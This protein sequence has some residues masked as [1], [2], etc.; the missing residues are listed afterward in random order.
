M[1]SSIIPEQLKN[2][3]I[4]LIKVEARGKN[5]I[6]ANWQKEGGSNFAYNDPII[7]NWL[8]NG[9]NYGVVTN[10]GLV[11]IDADDPRISKIVDAELP[12]TFTVKSGREGAGGFHYYYFCPEL[13][14]TIELRDENKKNIGHVKSTGGQVVGPGSIH[15]SGNAYKVVKNAPISKVSAEEVRF[16]LREL[17][18]PTSFD[19]TQDIIKNNPEATKDIDHLRIEK[20]IPLDGLS[21]HG[22]EYS[23]CCPWHDSS[24][25][26][27]FSVNTDKNEWHCWRHG[28]GGGPIQA[29]AVKHGIIEC[30]QAVKG[31]LRG[32]KYLDAQQIACDQYGLKIPK[33]EKKNK[34]ESNALQLVNLAK[35]DGRTE[36][37]HDIANIPYACVENNGHREVKAVQDSEFT[38]WLNGLS[39]DSFG[40]AP[41]NSA[42]ERAI[43]TLA[44]LAD[45]GEV[46]RVY[47]RHGSS[48]DELYYDLCNEECQSVRITKDGWEIVDDAPIMFRHYD[49]MLPQ[50]TP[51]RGGKGALKKL[52]GL[53]NINQNGRDIFSVQ[54]V[55]LCVPDI[56]QM[57][58]GTFGVEGTGKTTIQRLVSEACDPT[59]DTE[60]S[61]P[62][63]DNDLGL[64]LFTHRIAVFDNLTY[65]T[66][67]QSDILSRAG[68]GATDVKRSLFTNNGVNRRRYKVPT[69]F[70]GIS[71]TGAKPDFYD[72]NVIYRTM[73]TF[74]GPRLSKTKLGKK[75]RE[76]LPEALGEM[77]DILSDAMKCR[78]DFDEDN[79]DWKPRMTDWYLWALAVSKAMGKPDGWFEDRFRPMVEQRNFAISADD[80]LTVAM[81]YIVKNNG[82]VGT[83]QELYSHIND[84]DI[85][86]PDIC[87][88]DTR[89]QKWP[90]K[91]NSLGM[92]LEN[93]MVSLRS[94]DVYIS[95]GFWS[96][97]NKHTDKF[98]HL[99]HKRKGLER[100]A[101]KDNERIIIISS[102]PIALEGEQGEDK[103]SSTPSTPSESVVNEEQTSLTSSYDVT[104]EELVAPPL[105]QNI[106]EEMESFLAYISDKNDRGVSCSI[107]GL[108]MIFKEPICKQ[109]IEQRLIE[110]IEGQ[111]KL[112]VSLEP[113]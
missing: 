106:S 43:N 35:Q 105:V 32:E 103:E 63:N 10:N 27:N 21:Q 45:R 36:F 44:V 107:D 61:L 56:D 52:V 97:L 64:Y 99:V 55:V 4:R 16:A 7:T 112:L 73:E 38:K 83:A 28:T 104:N 68:T 100:N 96:D 82:F 31:A 90:N 19:S 80:P 11:A 41:E 49:H 79:V 47:T 69:F 17:I 6:D 1:N 50:V 86:I 77:F 113:L 109:A 78:D 53:A 2:S 95:K 12:K 39:V 24:T 67:E 34:I 81:E 87:N 71:V 22:S 5:P 30:S 8:S 58:A 48:G 75:I 62:K 51:I 91:A 74:N 46:R 20:I 88:I 29:I 26:N 93:M 18:E 85:G 9:G 108:M 98:K 72:R 94:H 111:A 66:G 33:T 84:Y 25:G 14:K 40:L 102:K 37:F 65:I 54:L 59:T 70:N 3:N 15:P 92:R 60:V 23:G 89:D 13:D 101:Y 110:D 57:G 42:V 76:L